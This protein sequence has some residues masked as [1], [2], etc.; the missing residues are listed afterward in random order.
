M[1]ERKNVYEAMMSDIETRSKKDEIKVKR[2]KIVAQRNC[3]NTLGKWL[4]NEGVKRK[5]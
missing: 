4:K 3:T 5:A 2:K 1:T